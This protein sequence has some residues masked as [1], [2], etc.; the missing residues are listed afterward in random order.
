MG[1]LNMAE[2]NK[3]KKK[4]ETTQRKRLNKWAKSSSTN[5]YNINR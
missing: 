1:Y 5:I 4:K 3:L 2:M